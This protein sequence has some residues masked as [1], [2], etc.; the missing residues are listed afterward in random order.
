MADE[1]SDLPNDTDKAVGYSELFELW[2]VAERNTRSG[3][4]S[5]KKDSGFSEWDNDVRSYLTAEEV[6]MF[7]KPLRPF[8]AK[9][10]RGG[11]G[12]PIARFVHLTKILWA[13][14]GID[15]LK[16]Y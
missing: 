10:R 5:L 13:R 16:D 15:K 11:P 6:E 7:N 12:T 9:Y 14:K 8:M 2:Q 3:E 4:W 1:L